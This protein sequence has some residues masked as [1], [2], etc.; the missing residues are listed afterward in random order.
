MVRWL[1]AA[2]LLLAASPAEAQDAFAADA[3]Y[4]LSG[5][6]A[7]QLRAQ[8][9]AK[10]PGDAID[11]LLQRLA[12]PADADR[13]PR[14]GDEEAARMA[15]SVEIIDERASETTYRA[16]IRVFFS[17]DAVRERLS[18]AGI[19]FA[20]TRS[21]PVLV[22]PVFQAGEGVKL[23]DEPNPWL[24]A[25]AGFRPPPGLIPIV[26]PLGDLEDVGEIGG[27]K[28]I[29]GDEGRL[30]NIAARYG[31]GDVILAQ[32]ALRATDDGKPLIEAQARRIGEFGAV[33]ANRSYTGQSFEQLDGVLTQ[34]AG[35]IWQA[36][37]TKWKQRNT[38][39]FGYENVLP[40]RADFRSLR[41]WAE[42][43]RRLESVNMV[44]GVTVGRLNRDGARLSV[45]YQGA[46][47]QLEI[48]LSQFDL[49][50]QPAGDV[51][52]IA[53]AEPLPENAAAPG[54]APGAPPAGVGRTMR[55]N[56]RAVDDPG[57]GGEVQV[58]Q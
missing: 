1:F 37:E 40:A 46:I 20:E 42:L 56:D 5:A 48:A 18:Q 6:P 33:L 54:R 29:I 51:W 31:A 7:S 49:T 27:D 50:L 32:A 19:R 23:W 13:T 39:R 11:E 30:L 21:K 14:I 44:R 43:R 34:V 36:A 2:A 26:V 8:A 17:D 4:D 12:V 47:E 53:L 57:T 45:A 3:R 9:M 16:T 25:W 22:L 24:R 10:A 15:E 55:A 35:R 58:L 28:S 38:I 41:E 52:R